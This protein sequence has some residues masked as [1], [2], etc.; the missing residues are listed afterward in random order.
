MRLLS[1][2]ILTQRIFLEG[3]LTHLKTFS[4]VHPLPPV[5][6]SPPPPELRV[7]VRVKWRISTCAQLTH[8]VRLM[9]MVSTE[10]RLYRQRA[11]MARERRMVRHQEREVGF[12]PHYLEA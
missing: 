5:T 3:L 6:G 9:L 11:L 1:C 7:G 4:S 10:S 12:E 2:T 8:G